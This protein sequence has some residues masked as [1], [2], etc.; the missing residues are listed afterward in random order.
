MS[1]MRIEDVLDLFSYRPSMVPDLMDYEIEMIEERCKQYNI[2]KDEML[3]F[4]KFKT[5]KSCKKQYLMKDEK[6]YNI[7]T[8]EITTVGELMT[9]L[10][11]SLATMV[12]NLK[13]KK[14]INDEYWSL[15]ENAKIS[16]FT[17]LRGS[18]T[19]YCNELKMSKT[20]K[21]WKAYFKNNK[22]NVGCYSNLN[23]RYLDQYTFKRER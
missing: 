8:G 15:D 4:E 22:F 14:I 2:C 17:N 5:T 16:Q 20:M 12:K 19:Y 13:S 11:Y 21:E 6:V 1:K 23:S 18:Y 9:R 7:V 3:R 10:G